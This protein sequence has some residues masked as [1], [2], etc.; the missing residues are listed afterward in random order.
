MVKAVAQEDKRHVGVVGAHLRQRVQKRLRVVHIQ[1]DRQAQRL[2]GGEDGVGVEAAKGIALLL[3][4]HAQGARPRGAQTLRH[5]PR[6]GDA[7]RIQTGIDGKAQPQPPAGCR[8]RALHEGVAHLRLAHGLGMIGQRAVDAV[9]VHPAQQPLRRLI[10]VR[11]Q[12][13]AD[14]AVDVHEFHQGTS[15]SF[16]SLIIPVRARKAIDFVNLVY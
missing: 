2:R 6:A 5:A 15:C 13:R 10:A 12:R 11:L 8:R 7:E 14:A 4:E 9:I 16:F 1:Q 3:R